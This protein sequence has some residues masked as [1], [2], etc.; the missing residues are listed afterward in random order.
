MNAVN[1]FKSSLNVS[2]WGCSIM[3]TMYSNICHPEG[4]KEETLALGSCTLIL[5]HYSIIVVH[6]F[7]RLQTSNIKIFYRNHVFLFSVSCKLS[8]NAELNLKLST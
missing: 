4:K 1:F 6:N 2:I 8:E 3:L 7:V 5:L